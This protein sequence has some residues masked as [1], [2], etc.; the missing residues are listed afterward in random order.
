[1]KNPPAKGLNTYLLPCVHDIV[2]LR[3]S[4]QCACLRTCEPIPPCFQFDGGHLCGAPA[5][6]DVLLRP[7]PCGSCLTG[8]LCLPMCLCLC[9]ECER[10]NVFG[11]VLLPIEAML[12]ASS[13]APAQFVAQADVCVCDAQ[14]QDGCLCVFF[15]L[16][17]TLYAA[18]LTPCSSRARAAGLLR[19]R[20][21]PPTST[22]PCIRSSGP[23]GPDPN[24]HICTQKK[25]GIP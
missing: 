5:L 23:R 3:L 25:E 7:A 16:M 21:A 12:R 4:R 18:C 17:L 1:M 2:R 24:L 15:D 13:C 9:C 6:Q 19:A 10:R 8:Q 22:C 11:S 14:M 20:T